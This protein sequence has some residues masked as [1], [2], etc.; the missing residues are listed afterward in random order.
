L[1]FWNHENRFIVEPGDFKVTVG[2]SSEGGLE[3][4]F[5]VIN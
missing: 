1:G 5:T 3:A 4:V 2:N